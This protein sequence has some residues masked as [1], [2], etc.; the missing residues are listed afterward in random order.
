MDRAGKSS[1]FPFAPAAMSVYGGLVMTPC[2]EI[3]TG[4]PQGFAEAGEPRGNSR[5]SLGVQ[6][7]LVIKG[8]TIRGAKHVGHWVIL[9]L[10]FALSA[11]AMALAFA[12]SLQ[13]RF[14]LRG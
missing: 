14:E 10:R 12:R 7:A 3:N 6:R 8:A 4:F 2:V 11:R 13:N 1:Q 9:I 5:L